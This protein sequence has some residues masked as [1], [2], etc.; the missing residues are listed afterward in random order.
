[1]FDII[2]RNQF[3]WRRTSRFEQHGFLNKF[4]VLGAQGIYDD[5]CILSIGRQ[6]L[7]ESKFPG[8]NNSF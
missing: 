4:R 3:L 5:C 6:Y 1:M 7:H 8:P 2:Y